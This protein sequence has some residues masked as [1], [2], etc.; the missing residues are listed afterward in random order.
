M[1][2]RWIDFVKEYA[3]EN[4]ISYKESLKSE[5]AKT[6]YRK[7]LHS[8][9]VFGR[10]FIEVPKTMD[11]IDKQGKESEINTLTKSGNFTRRNKKPAMNLIENDSNKIS[12]SKSLSK[13]SFSNKIKEGIQNLK[14]VS[15]TN[16]R[17]SKK[18]QPKL[19]QQKIT[20]PHYEYDYTFVQRKK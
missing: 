10:P 3:R 16:S 11:Y 1:V 20:N 18:V 9:L 4:N 19:K 5:S 13:Q 7:H 15:K 12:V 14:S 2:N 17:D 8:L 6:E